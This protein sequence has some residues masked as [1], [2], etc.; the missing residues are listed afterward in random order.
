MSNKPTVIEILTMDEI[1]EIT[2]LTGKSFE[3]LFEKGLQLGKPSKALCWVLA[4]RSNPDA[5]LDDF[6]K[7]NITEIGT[8]LEGFLNNPKEIP[9]S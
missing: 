8:F 6:G 4:K 3:D 5:K 1:E 7:M 2:L 9:N